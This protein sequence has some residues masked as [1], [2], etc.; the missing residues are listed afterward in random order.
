MDYYKKKKFKN[1][2]LLLVFLCG[3]YLQVLGHNIPS[4]KGLLIQFLS[5]GL[6][7]LTLYL[8]NKRYKA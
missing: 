8:Y 3:V 5:L 7:I 2:I 6:L 4:Y 1:L